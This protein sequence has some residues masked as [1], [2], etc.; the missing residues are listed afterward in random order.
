MIHASASGTVSIIFFFLLFSQP[1]FIQAIEKRW[2]NHPNVAFFREVMEDKVKQ[3]D[4]RRANRK[5]SGTAEEAEEDSDSDTASET[6]SEEDEETKNKNKQFEDMHARMKVW[7][8]QL[9]SGDVEGMKEELMRVGI[10]RNERPV[11]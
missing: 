6:S 8:E 3:L 7:E 4:V 11:E 9:E 2:P 1:P 10:L 5:D